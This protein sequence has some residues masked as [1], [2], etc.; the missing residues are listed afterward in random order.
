MNAHILPLYNGKATHLQTVSF[1]IFTILFTLLSPQ[2]D[3]I[4]IYAPIF[5][6]LIDAIPLLQNMLRTTPSICAF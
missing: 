6:Q 4:S 3:V 2:I 5:H 1:N